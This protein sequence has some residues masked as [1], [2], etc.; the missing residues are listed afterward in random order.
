MNRRFKLQRYALP[1]VLISVVATAVIW[2]SRL[3]EL[4]SFPRVSTQDPGPYPPALPDSDYISSTA[5]RE[6]HAEQH[7]SWHKTYHR[8][9]TQVVTPQTMLAPFEDV[10]LES[11]GRDY[12]LSREAETYWVDLVDPEWDVAN[13]NLGLDPDPESKPPRV[14]RQVVLSTGSHNYQTY[15]FA[16]G[17]GNQLRQLP[18]VY[19]IADRRWIP[20]E[21]AFLSPPDSPRRLA[22]W[23][24]NCIQCHAVHGQPGRDEATDTLVTQVTE[25]GIACEACHGPGRAH[26]N[27]QRQLAS[28]TGTNSN[29][30]H[31]QASRPPDP[32]IVNPDRLSHKRASQVCGQCHSDFSFT[33]PQFWKTG[34]AFRPGDDLHETRLIHTF[35]EQYVQSHPDIWDGFW[36]DGTMR[37]AGREYSAM[38]DSACYL[39]GEISCMSCHSMHASKP[40]GQIDPTRLG[41][42]SCLQCHAKYRE[43]TTAHT[44]HLPSSSGSRC[45][46][47]HMPH[48]SFGLLKAVRSHRIDSPHTKMT[49]EH[50]R[51]NACNLCHLDRPLSWTGTHLA[52]WYGQPRT[53]LDDSQASQTSA[54]LQHLLS[55]DAVQR[56]ITAWHM[57]WTPAQSA[58]GQNWQAPFLAELLQDPYAAV[59]YIAFHSLQQLAGYEEFEYDFV[60]PQ[61]ARRIAAD[62]AR[63]KWNGLKPPTTPDRNR[64]LLLKPD[65]TLDTVRFQE[66]L[67]KRND[68]PLVF[69]E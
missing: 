48:T 41:D 45:V 66:L 34:F 51:P 23:N 42:E 25:Y 65:G 4:E 55:G 28:Q 14:R 18:W 9:M 54:A 32:T 1:L 43:Q 22:V 12:H 38:I 5:C 46:N 62:R 47:C 59:R 10:K 11:R 17:S 19:H 39:R 30:E 64:Q 53:T 40:A 27:R 15:W 35:N 6:C 44:H 36:M 61:D 52:E 8:S 56:A 50:G 26:V 63:R 69:P 31:A 49:A 37:V 3:P 57:G 2:W 33:N 20:A 21:D 24:D 58:S 7:A 68:Q 29:P 13:A 16:S 67:R 60:G